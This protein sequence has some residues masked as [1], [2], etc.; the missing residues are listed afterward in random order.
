MLGEVR[1]TGIHTKII[2]FHT[3]PYEIQ[4]FKWSFVRYNMTLLNEYK[5][6]RLLILSIQPIMRQVSDAKRT[7]MNYIPFRLL[8]TSIYNYDGRLLMNQPLKPALRGGAIHGVD[9]DLFRAPEL[10]HG[11]LCAG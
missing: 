11:R 6:R 9:P 10:S 3:T 5:Q 1:Q 7:R 2:H 8:Y 4:S